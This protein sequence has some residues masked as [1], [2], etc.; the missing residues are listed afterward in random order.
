MEFNIAF[1]TIFYISIFIIPGILIRRFYFQGEFSKEFSQGNLLERLMWTIF[2]SI[3]ALLTSAAFFLVIRS[4][5]KEDLLPAISYSTIKEVFDLLATNELPE[6]NRF[7][8]IYSDFLIL[9]C[10]IYVLSIGIGILFHRFVLFFGGDRA[11]FKFRNYWYYFF[12]GRVKGLVQ[13]KGRTYWYTEADIL[14]EQDGKAKKYSGKVSNYFVDSLNNQLESIFLEDTKRYEFI[15][16]GSQNKADTPTEEKASAKIEL[17]IRSEYEL[18]DIPGD[19]F[20]IPYHRVLNINFTYVSKEK[21]ISFWRKLLG[22]LANL[23]YII[24][25]IGIFSFFWIENL[26]YLSFESL[27]FKIWFVMNSFIILS[28]LRSL[29]EQLLKIQDLAK[30]IASSLVHGVSATFFCLQFLWIIGDRT[31]ISTFLISFFAFIIVLSV[32]ESA[33]DEEHEDT[34]T[35]VEGKEGSFE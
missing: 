16:L 30:K 2:S 32:I 20:C 22:I 18:I 7:K 15:D 4:V 3:F 35:P 23:L 11:L 6:G 28:I 1:N 24:G 8:V 31:F 17:D 29:S 12:R 9:I 26:P 25:V 10:G 21:G 13:K 14:V 33:T 27:W 5:Y 19:V 34:D